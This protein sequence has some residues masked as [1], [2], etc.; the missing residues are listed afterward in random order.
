MIIPIAG[1]DKVA[2]LK[3]ITRCAVNEIAN[4]FSFTHFYKQI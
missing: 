4:A 3:Q 2:L 1:P